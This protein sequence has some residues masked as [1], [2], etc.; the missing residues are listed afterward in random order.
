MIK[1]A[2]LDELHDKKGLA[3]GFAD[4]MDFDNVVVVDL[5]QQRRFAMEAGPQLLGEAWGVNAHLD[6]DNPVQA[7]LPGLVNYPHPAFT[8]Q[9]KDLV[10]GNRR[11][12]LS[13]S[14]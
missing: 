7:D 3:V 14:G 5:S 8:Q 12:F 11:Q 4:F 13:D 6:C 2:T 1:A 10:A 9:A